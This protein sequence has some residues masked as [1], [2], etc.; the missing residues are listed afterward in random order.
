MRWQLACIPLLFFTTVSLAF[1]QKL[2]GLELV[3]A[4]NDTVCYGLGKMLRSDMHCRPLDD[5]PCGPSKASGLGAYPG[6][7]Y[8]QIAVNEYGYTEIALPTVSPKNGVA[9][10]YVEEFQGDHRARLMEVWKIA[11]TDLQHVLALPPGPMVGKNGSQISVA[12]ETNSAAFSAMLGHGQ[13]VA[14]EWSPVVSFG[15]AQFLISRECERSSEGW[16]YG[17]HVCPKVTAISVYEINSHQPALQ[18]K[19]RPRNTARDDKNKK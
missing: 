8:K 4:R 9:I 3:Y 6:D 2:H 12:K 18:C 17:M 16:S 14:N 15:E 7:F 1:A 5:T 10:V 13:K 11:D 19:F